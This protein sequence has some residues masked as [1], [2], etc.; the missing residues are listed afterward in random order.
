MKKRHITIADL[1]I[2]NKAKRYV[3]SV[4][5]KNRLSYGPFTEKFEKEFARL[6][7]RQYATVSNSGTSALHVAI[8]AM[9]EAYVWDDD[10]E[11]LVPAFAFI[12]SSNAI[13]HNDLKPAPDPNSTRIP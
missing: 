12:A 1:K 9:K 2:S 5:D 7:K 8:Y 3:R 13:A 6:H 11:I 4:L 10:D